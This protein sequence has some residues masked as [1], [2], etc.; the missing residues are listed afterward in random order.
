VLYNFLFFILAAYFVSRVVISLWKVQVRLRSAFK[1]TYSKLTVF[2]YSISKEQ[3]I[4]TSQKTIQSFSVLYPSLTI[5]QYDEETHKTEKWFKGGNY[6][7]IPQMKNTSLRTLTYTYE[8]GDRLYV[9]VLMSKL[10]LPGSL[11]SFGAIKRLRVFA[12][13]WASN[14]NP[15]IGIT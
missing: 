8:Q 2:N 11:D 1:P 10:L 3:K 14:Y 7:N 4:G 5:C 6:L 13:Y 9:N 12:P 15:H